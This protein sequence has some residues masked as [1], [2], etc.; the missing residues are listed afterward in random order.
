MIDSIYMARTKS[1]DPDKI[2]EKAMEVFWEKGYE[3]ASLSDLTAATGLHKGSL[4]GAFESKENLFLLA[5]KKYGERS[6]EKLQLKGCPKQF[7]LDFFNQLIDEGSSVKGCKGCMIMNSALEL[8]NE[9]SK[10]SK[11]AKKLFQ[12]VESNIRRAV[13]SYSREV[14]AS[15]DVQ[16]ASMRLMGAAFAIRQFSRFM[17][18]SDY[19]RSIANGAL[20]ELS[21]K[22]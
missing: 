22:V 3:G 2:L 9:K 13:E 20:K 4:Y 1:F 15:I 7:L 5:L 19:L 17:N 18:D 10:L 14:K 11:L 6:R 21:L 8:G 16:E 12:E